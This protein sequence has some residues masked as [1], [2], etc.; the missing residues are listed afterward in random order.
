MKVN[1]LVYPNIT[2]ARNIEADSYVVAVRSMI[3]NLL[4]TRD[5]L[6]FTMLLPEPVYALDVPGVE[7]VIYDPGPSM[8]NTMRAHFNTR[9]FI[10]AIDWK[11]KSYDVVW[12]HLPEHTLA[13][14]NVFMNATNERPTFVGYAHWFEVPENTTYPATMLMHNLAGVLSMRECGVNS[15]W[16]RDLVI[17]YADDMLHPAL[18]ESIR[19][20]LTVQ[21]LGTDG[22]PR[23]LVPPPVDPKLIVFNHRA[24]EYTGFDDTLAAF[25][26]LWHRRQDFRV[27]FTLTSG[28]PADKF[29]NRPWAVTDAAPT[30]Y[31]YLMR[32]G[33]AAVGIGMFKRYSAW[34][35]SVMDG[36]SMGVPY[37]LPRGLCYPEMVGDD[38]ALLHTG[39]RQMLDHVEWMMDNPVARGTESMRATQIAES[40]EWPAR[41]GP[42]QRMFDAAIAALPAIKEATD[43]YERVADLARREYTKEDI[44]R[45]MGWWPGARVPWTPYRTRLR[46]DGIDVT[47]AAEQLTLA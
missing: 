9:A 15:A 40:F 23:G 24:S 47:T 13:I 44:M 28:V 26:E 14:R 32:L 10:D 16:L 43:T 41:I 29:A 2:Y 25:D 45:H 35:V 30:R 5:D 38:H 8:P 1:V 7:Q 3:T 21:Y 6:A 39:W 46:A 27:W 34:S 18:V 33:Q 19:S 17:G 31:E 37:T 12:S 42:Y 4:R 20:I 36:M 22:P 11:R